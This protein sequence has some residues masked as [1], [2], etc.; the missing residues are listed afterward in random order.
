MSFKI[1]PPFRQ[2]DERAAGKAIIRKNNRENLIEK[3]EYTLRLG[4]SNI[5]I[6]IFLSLYVFIYMCLI[7]HVF[8]YYNIELSVV[9]VVFV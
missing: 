1:C 3:N 6:L 2:Q 7:G 5:F 8:S 4:F 9:L